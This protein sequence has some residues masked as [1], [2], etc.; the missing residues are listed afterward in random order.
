MTCRDSGGRALAARSSVTRLCLRTRATS[1][2]LLV[3]APHKIDFDTSPPR[4]VGRA[5]PC[6]PQSA[7][8]PPNGAHGVARPTLLRISG[9]TI[10]GTSPLQR[11]VLL[12]TQGSPHPES[13]RRSP[14]RRVGMETRAGSETG[15]PSPLPVQGFIARRDSPSTGPKSDVLIA[16]LRDS[17]SNGGTDCT[18]NET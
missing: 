9:V 13:E 3:L 16:F 4:E 5:T 14:I 18:D 15:A 8:G 11:N 10:V 17:R 12:K 1:V 2:F 6:A 7:T